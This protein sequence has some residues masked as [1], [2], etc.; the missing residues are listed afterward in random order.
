MEI[1]EW[2]R[3]GWVAVDFKEFISKDFIWKNLSERIATKGLSKNCFDCSGN[4]WKVQS[5]LIIPLYQPT[6]WG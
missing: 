5:E 6:N 2:D 3:V 1:F 4:N